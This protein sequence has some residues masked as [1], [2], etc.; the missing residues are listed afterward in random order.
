MR[1]VNLLIVA[2]AAAGIA[3]GAYFVGHAVDEPAK[4]LDTVVSTPARAAGAAAQ[5]NLGAAVSA[6]ASYRVDH[7]TFAGM[8]TGDLRSYDHA[9]ASGVSV[10][11]ATDDAYCVES[12]V[13]GA[14]VSCG[15]SAWRTSTGF[16]D[17][18]SATLP[19]AGCK[20]CC[21]PSRLISVICLPASIG[22]DAA[23]FPPLGR[24]STSIFSV[25]HV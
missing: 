3:V 10:K 13:S 8:S 21:S 6:A 23:T 2:A 4:Q 18:E 12:T 11:K 20:A 17:S 7:G 5:A 1:L 22:K 16:S 24:Q 15:G 25:P 9:I 19:P 14:T